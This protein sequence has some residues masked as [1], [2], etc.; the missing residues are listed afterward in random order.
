MYIKENKIAGAPN[1]NIFF[2]TPLSCKNTNCFALLKINNNINIYSNIIQIYNTFIGV[3]TCW[4]KNREILIINQIDGIRQIKGT[5]LNIFFPEKKHIDVTINVIPAKIEKILKKVNLNKFN[6]DKDVSNTDIISAPPLQI[7]NT[8]IVVVTKEMGKLGNIFP[9]LGTF[10]DKNAP[11]NIAIINNTNIN[12]LMYN[13]L[14]T[15]KD[16]TDDTNTGFTT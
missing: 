6:R 8:P 11:T 1:I 3:T 12:K 5:L 15:D 4:I 13:K 2:T 10:F 7:A 14:F 9:L 16:V